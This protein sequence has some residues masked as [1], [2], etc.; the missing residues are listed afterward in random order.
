MPQCN[1]MKLIFVSI[2]FLVILATANACSIDFE[3]VTLELRSDTDSYAQNITAEDNDDVTIRVKFDIDEVSGNDCANDIEVRAQIYRQEDND[4]WELFDTLE[5]DEDLDEDD[6]TFTFDD[7]F[8]VDDDYSRYR[9]NVT[10]F[11][12]NEEYEDERGYVDVVNN[13]CS[14]IELIVEDFD[15]DE[16]EEG[17]ETF[18]IE[19]NTNTEFRISELDTIFSNSLIRS[20]DFDYSETVEENSEEEVEITLS[21]GY[22]SRDTTTTGTF[23]VAG[24]LGSNFCSVSSVGRESFDVTVEDTGSS[25]LD[26]DDDD[27]DDDYR[28]ISDCEDITIV[29]NNISILEGRET[30][31]NFYLQND[32]TKRFEILEI[33]LTDNGVELDNYYNEK[34]AS[35]NG[36]ADIAV[37][38]K[39]EN[40]FSNKSFEN[41]IKVRG[42]FS[43]GKTCSFSNIRSETFNVNV[44]NS[45]S[46]G[47]T[48][49]TNCNNFSISAQD[50]ISI[51]NFGKIPFTITNGTNQRADI[52]VEG[53]LD[54]SPSLISLPANSSI[55]RELDVTILSSN[56]EIVLRPV[57]S[58]CYLASKRI[59]VTN[60]AKGNFSSLTMN[61]DFEN[62]ETNGE[63]NIEIN[64][65]TTKIYSGVIT[66]D[67]P[68][69]WSAS[70]RSVTITPGTNNITINL[71]RTANAESGR[72]RVTF[73]SSGE[74]ISEE[75]SIGN[76]ALA[77]LF[78]LGAL[79]ISNLATILL[80]ILAVLLIVGII[81]KVTEKSDKKQQEWEE[82][83]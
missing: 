22:V 34:Y 62:D 7:A 70:S 75:F 80:I 63:I 37:S 26:D 40:V 57:V 49:Y 74:E 69:G 31:E 16:G 73:S 41:T 82:K 58:G 60:K 39:T 35:A 48:S 45:D 23:T 38:V 67:G 32:A 5:D 71:T 3:D 29:A 24:Y 19:N 72:G 21:V 42:K 10:I 76:S 59:S 12:V 43:D 83:D 44:E 27:E 55:S 8:E 18:I 17:T 66:F 9:V 15:I 11:D 46:I 56:G 65:P 6:Y 52:Y 50:I 13:S 4:D 61:L 20:G 14:G 28:G 30:I 64:N 81:T 36:I 68:Q 53:T 25:S 79:G 54:A 51:E 78:S 2:L 47:L 77:G 1:V 33:Q